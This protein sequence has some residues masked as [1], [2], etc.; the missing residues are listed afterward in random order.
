MNE[1]TKS[2]GI[3][4]EEVKQI[5]QESIDDSANINELLQNVANKIYQKGFKEPMKLK[6]SETREEYWFYESICPKCGNRWI[7][8]GTDHF[9][10]RCGQPV[11]EPCEE[12]QKDGEQE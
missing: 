1:D 11:F 10:P 2:M 4:F 12:E 5:F 9:C 6:Y 8:S 3:S 7:S